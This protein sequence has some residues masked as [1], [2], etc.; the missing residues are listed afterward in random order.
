LETIL[1]VER[2]TN[3]LKN[4]VN[5]GVRFIAASFGFVLCLSDLLLGGA[6]AALVTKAVVKVPIALIS[7]LPVR[8]TIPDP[9]LSSVRCRSYFTVIDRV[10]DPHELLR[11]VID[12]GFAGRLNSPL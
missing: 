10:A 3:P 11:T 5:D 1:N 7:A 12:C 8:L 2:R 4:V 6:P 9:W